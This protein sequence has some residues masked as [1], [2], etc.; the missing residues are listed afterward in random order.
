MAFF[1]ESNEVLS[2]FWRAT[3]QSA[4]LALLVAATILVSRN[5]LAAKW[6]VVLWML[7]MCRMLVLVVPASG[8]SIFNGVSLLTEAQP[9]SPMA[10]S[11]EIEGPPLALSNTASPIV[12]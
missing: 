6:R 2:L 1:N 5:W 7:P 12:G 9:V 8:L 11:K 3:W 4:V 10:S